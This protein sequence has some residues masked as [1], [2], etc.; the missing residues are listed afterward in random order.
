MFAALFALVAALA[1]AL[2]GCDSDSPTPPAT[3]TP[4]PTTTAPAPD[5]FV[6]G[7]DD[8]V[9]DPEAGIVTECAQ[10]QLPEE[11]EGRAID[12]HALAA[13]PAAATVEAPAPLL[14]ALAPASDFTP[15]HA[16]VL[17]EAADRVCEGATAGV[18]VV[19]MADRLVVEL[20]LTDEE[21][22]TFVNTAATVHCVSAP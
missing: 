22:R 2:A 7:P 13:D 21:A 8:P 17:V 11:T 12:P 1:V 4:A 6:P 10:G 9:C 14:V 15:E 20:S 3:T 5:T 19:E 18:P 16:A